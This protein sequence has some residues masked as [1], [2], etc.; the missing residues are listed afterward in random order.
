M[1]NTNEHNML[2]IKDSGIPK[3]YGVVELFI[4]LTKSASKNILQVINKI[5]IFGFMGK[6]DIMIFL[7][8]Q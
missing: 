5:L 6:N 7:N 1:H 4:M 2:K 8:N 3:R